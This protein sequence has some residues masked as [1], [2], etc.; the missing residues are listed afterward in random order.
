[1]ARTRDRGQ[2]VHPRE[3]A[4]AHGAAMMMPRKVLN[5]VGP[6]CEGYLIYIEELDWAERVRSARL[7]VWIE[8]GAQGKPHHR[9]NGA[10]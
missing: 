3:T 4:C 5:Q 7:E 6:M 9:Q 1:M 2:F 10:D 8:P